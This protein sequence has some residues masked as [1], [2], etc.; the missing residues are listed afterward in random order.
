MG[1]PNLFE[2]NEKTI[3][4]QEWYSLLSE[5]PDDYNNCVVKTLTHV[6]NLH[7]QV[8][9]EY[10]QAIIE[11]LDT[12]NRTR[13]IA[14][15]QTGQD[16]VI[17]GRWASSKSFTLSS[18]GGI[19]SSGGSS[20]DLPLP[21][22]SLT[23]KSD[24][25]KVL[26]LAGI[27]AKTTKIGGNYNLFTK[28]CYWFAITSYT[29]LKL[30]FSGFEERLYFWG[31]RGRLIIFKRSAEGRDNEFQEERNT[32]MQCIPSKP[33]PTW[34]FLEE[35]YKGVVRLQANS[36][37]EAE[38]I[39]EENLTTY[40]MSDMDE[41]KTIGAMQDM[42]IPASLSS[43]LGLDEIYQEAKQLGK[44][45]KYIKVY[46]NYKDNEQA[47]EAGIYDDNEVLVPDDFEVQEPTPEETEKLDYV[48]Q[49]M[50]GQI[51]SEN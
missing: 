45:S 47:H 25:L 28:G 46:N 44:V 39:I 9:H 5:S 6:K 32:R 11:D 33:A 49:A 34:D 1:I 24:N 14:E 23:F 35:V 37:E 31:W 7:S 48:I 4:T 41:N 42:D 19:S 15:R 26:D 43:D 18:G 16:Q 40:I 10:L 3:E 36:D 27:L 29:A 21:L 20:K 30:K 38:E 13:L 12:G 51:L 17:L 22:F 8:D 2:D 50:V